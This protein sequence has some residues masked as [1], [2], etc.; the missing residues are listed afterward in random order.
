MLFRDSR[1]ARSPCLAP[2]CYRSPWKPEDTPD[3]PFHRTF[4]VCNRNVVE[5]E[6]QF[7]IDCPLYSDLRYDIF[8][9]AAE[10]IQGFYN[11]SSDNKFT[12]ILGCET[13]QTV[14]SSYVQ[15]FF[16]R[17]KLFKGENWTLLLYCI[18]I[19][20]II[21]MAL[22]LSVWMILTTWW[23]EFEPMAM[24]IYLYNFMKL[25]QYL[26]TQT[27]NQENILYKHITQ[28]F[29]SIWTA[30]FK[31]TINK[32]C[33]LQLSLMVDHGVAEGTCSQVLRSTSVES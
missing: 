29:E 17:G 6:K 32:L 28:Q 31:H 3:R 19:K 30:Y 7:L 12:Y 14:V 13:L 4:R 20:N 22:D 21:C 27:W 23:L 5:N 1:D 9:T 18:Y 10:L 24:L 33:G 26:Y 8:H 16:N 15:I 2:G 25:K 11:L